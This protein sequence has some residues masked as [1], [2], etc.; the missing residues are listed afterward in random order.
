[1]TTCCLRYFIA[2]G[3]LAEFEEYGRTW[4]RLIEKYGGVHHGCFMPASAPDSVSAKH[5]SFPG[6]GFEGPADV[7][8]VL[9]S[10]RDLAAYNEYRRLAASDDECRQAAARLQSSG[11]LLRYERSFVRKI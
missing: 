11:C 6:L 1:M 7:A 8:I 10:F 4:V 9:Y 5:F 3:K 2:P